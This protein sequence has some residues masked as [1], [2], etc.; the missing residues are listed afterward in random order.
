M[1]LLFPLHPVVGSYY[2]FSFHSQQQVVLACLVVE[3]SDFVVDRVEQVVVEGTV[4]HSK[5]Y[6][7][8]GIEVDLAYEV[9]GARHI[10]GATVD[11]PVQM[12]SD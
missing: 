7:K 2:Q 8:L 9:L 5:A 10:A 6:G 11:M 3:Y 1:D 4:E 12:E